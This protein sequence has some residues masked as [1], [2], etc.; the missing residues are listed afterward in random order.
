M[1]CFRGRV[2]V[3]SKLLAGVVWVV[4]ERK[5]RDEVGF[6]SLRSVAC[7]AGL[8]GLR[9]LGRTSMRGCDTL[10]FSN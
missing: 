5:L 4:A 7:F 2:E 1:V 8:G 3:V 6:S 9:V 10:R